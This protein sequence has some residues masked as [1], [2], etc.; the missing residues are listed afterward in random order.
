MLLGVVVILVTV[1]G[2]LLAFGDS[3]EYTATPQAENSEV[4]QNVNVPDKVAEEKFVATHIETPENVRGVY[5]TSWLGGVKD[6][7][8]NFYAR[9]NLMK[10]IDETELNSMVIDIK[11]DT[12]N[13]AYE[14]FD[15]ELKKIGSATTRIP[16]IRAFLK[17]LHEKNIYA[18]GRIA[19]FQDPYF[20]KLHPE[21][22]VKRASD[23]GVWKDR[24][25]LT[26]LD[27]GA[28]GVWD[29]VIMIAK[30]AYNSGFDEVQFDY[31]RFPTDGNLQDIAYPFFDSAQSTRA[32]Q[33]D[34]FFVYAGNKL[35]SANIP[36]SVDLFGL[37]MTAMD[38]L[39]IGQILELAA[40]NFDFVSPMVYPSHFAKG[41]YGYENPN[42]H[43]YD[44]VK[45]ALIGGIA[46]LNNASTS[47]DKIR[48]WLQ[49]FDYGGRYDATAVRAQIQAVYDAG[50]TSWLLWDPSVKYEK[51]ALLRQ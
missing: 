13:I 44:I 46:K 32:I 18:I 12:G 49:D 31:V 39:G 43:S 33:M 27:A 22:A 42:D 2:A 9:E 8:G 11:D 29:Y 40:A 37:T 26:W 48:P 21:L 15:H 30:D 24:K 23:G 17:K 50:L 14:V 7:D 19:V 3:Y 47:P 4:A 36:A 20:V 34:K 10:M 1:I 25:G 35:S 5:M 41:S 28:Q 38:D 51:D 6:S 45:E 16:D